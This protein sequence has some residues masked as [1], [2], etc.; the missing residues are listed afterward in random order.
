MAT[1]VYSGCKI[2]RKLSETENQDFEKCLI[3]LRQHDVGQYSLRAIDLRNNKTVRFDLH[4][5]SFIS[6]LQSPRKSLTF[7]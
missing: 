2:R 6:Q 5:S 7:H 4:H 3:E 1:E